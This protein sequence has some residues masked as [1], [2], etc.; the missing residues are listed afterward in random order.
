[1]HTQNRLL[2]FLCTVIISGAAEFHILRCNSIVMA[3]VSTQMG[4]AIFGLS[5]APKPI[6]IGF[7]FLIARLARKDPVSIPEG[8]TNIQNVM[9]LTKPFKPSNKMAI[10]FRSFRKEEEKKKFGQP[11]YNHEK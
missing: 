7:G 10:I 2:L 11:Q 4:M 6:Y 5:L 8:K 3:I 9:K 1:M